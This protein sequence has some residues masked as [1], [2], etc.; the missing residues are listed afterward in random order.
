MSWGGHKHE[1]KY[2][3]ELQKRFIAM[4]FVD[5]LEAIRKLLGM[6]T[7]RFSAL[8]GISSRR[9][10][11][12]IMYYSLSEDKQQEIASL[13]GVPLN[14]MQGST[15]SAKI[16]KKVISDHLTQLFNKEE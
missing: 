10:Y 9:Y 4:N 2:A 1:G 11:S 15:S 6:K 13:L 8:I 14:V 12:L 7:E 3:I 16:D 5:N